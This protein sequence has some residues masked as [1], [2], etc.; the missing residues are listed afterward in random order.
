[1]NFNIKER[2]PRWLGHVVRMEDDRIPKQAMYW[3]MDHHVKHKPGRPRTNWIDT[4]CQDLKTIA[5][6]SLCY[7]L[8]LYGF[9]ARRLE[10][11]YFTLYNA[12][13]HLRYSVH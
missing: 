11:R 6:L 4:I 7:K 9:L 12:A 13:L 3:Q 2:R 8:L 10:M 5:V 1:M